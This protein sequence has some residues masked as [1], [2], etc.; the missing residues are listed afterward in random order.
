M[1]GSS[2]PS[3]EASDA[4]S[5]PSALLDACYDALRSA[6]Q[7]HLRAE[8][9]GHTLQ[10]T[11]LIHEAFLRLAHQ[12]QVRFADDDHFVALAATMMRRILV[13]HA[14]ARS[15]QKRGGQEGAITLHEEVALSGS[16][17]EV[18]SVDLVDLDRALDLL[19]A[20]SARQARVVE[21]RFFGGMSIE[22]TARLL[23]V[24]ARTVNTDWQVAR[25]FLHR[26]MSDDA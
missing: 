23:N 1:S 2:L 4:T 7:R 26:A 24:T 22:Q 8:N 9:P 21:L 19:A 14:R 25:A 6:A 17:S 3:H 10:P 15:A 11:A 20:R 5:I 12:D 18:S 13:D 16:D